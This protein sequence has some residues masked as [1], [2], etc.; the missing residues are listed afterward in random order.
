MRR[1]QPAA[2][3]AMDVDGRHSPCQMAAE[4]LT[5]SFVDEPRAEP[6]QVRQPLVVT[7]EYCS[8]CGDLAGERVHVCKDCGAYVCEQTKRHGRGCIYMGTVLPTPGFRCPACN[9]K[10]W[11]GLSNRP[12]GGLPVSNPAVSAPKLGVTGR[13]AVRF[14]RLCRQETGK[15][16]LAPGSRQHDALHQ[17]RE[18]PRR[19]AQAGPQTRV[20][21]SPTEC[22]SS[23][24]THRSE[25]KETEHAVVARSSIS[26]TCP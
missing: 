17:R 13:T 25:E 4:L 23:E 20:S 15:A 10:H 21:G 18:L 2:A 19:F 8:F 24:N 3:D 11:R 7:K 16:N 22:E 1:K 6:S 14:H 26:Q 12:N 5:G 9:A